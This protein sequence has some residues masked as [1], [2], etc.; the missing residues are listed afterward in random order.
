MFSFTEYIHIEEVDN[1]CEEELLNE[2]DVVLTNVSIS[3]SQMRALF[4]HTR[5]SQTLE[6]T[7]PICKSYFSGFRLF[8]DFSILLCAKFSLKLAQKHNTELKMN[9]TESFK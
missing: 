7:N 9:V 6:V 8:Q 4:G 2:C 5:V 1:L 3:V